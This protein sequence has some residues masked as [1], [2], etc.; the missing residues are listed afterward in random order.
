MP[1][2]LPCL[3]PDLRFDL[4]VDRYVLAIWDCWHDPRPV[5]QMEGWLAALDKTTQGGVMQY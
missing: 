1:R 5:I 4:H 2:S 3:S